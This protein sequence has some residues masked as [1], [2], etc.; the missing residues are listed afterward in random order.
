MGGNV[1]VSR[2]RPILAKPNIPILCEFAHSNVL[3]AFD[4]D[5][6]LAPIASTPERARMRR[7]TEELLK[8][9]SDRYPSVVISGRM[10]DDIAGRV[11]PIPL[12][13]VF[14]NH[15]LEPIAPASHVGNRLTREWLRRLREG[16]PDYQGVII[17]DKRH[18]VTI[19]YRAA[20]DRRRAM[21]AIDRAVRDLPDVRVVGGAEAVNLLPR[22]GANKGVALQRA[23]RLFKC[24]TAIY[25]GDDDTDEDAFAVEGLDRIL[26]IR[27]G[28]TTSSRARYHLVSQGEIDAFLRTLAG[29]RRPRPTTRKPAGLSVGVSSRAKDGLQRDSSTAAR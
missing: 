3:V 23:A 10:L 2:T 22:D 20:R 21:A 14:G 8:R 15:G 29:M 19:H 11:K 4:Y 25:V 18:T 6:T 5:G 26:G 17:E 1:S 9:V 16:L 28:A 7:R 13:Y 27:I 12:R 24:S